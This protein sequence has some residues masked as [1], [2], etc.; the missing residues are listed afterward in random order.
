MKRGKEQDTLKVEIAQLL[1]IAPVAPSKK[2]GLNKRTIP[3]V[4]N[5]EEK[6]SFAIERVATLPHLTSVI[7][8]TDSQSYGLRCDPAQNFVHLQAV[9]DLKSAPRL[10]FTIT[11]TKNGKQIFNELLQRYLQRMYKRQDIDP[12]KWRR[13]KGLIVLNMS[14]DTEMFCTS[15][16]SQL[17]E[18]SNFKKGF[19]KN[20]ENNIY[21]HSPSL[22]DIPKF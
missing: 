16:T 11:E 9:S 14:A 20:G 7:K 5:P 22:R 10:L 8:N 6:Q 15:Y 19:G 2:E 4:R 21:T 3:T 18:I 12:Q 13:W 1:G 17:Q